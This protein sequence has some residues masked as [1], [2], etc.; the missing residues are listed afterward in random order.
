MLV[1][2]NGN[3]IGANPAEPE[4]DVPGGGGGDSI[5]VT[6][7][8]TPLSGDSPLL[9][10]FTGNAVSDQAIDESR[11]QWDF[12]SDGVID[13]YTRNTSHEYEAQPGESRLYTARLTMYGRQRQLR[14]RDRP[15]RGRGRRR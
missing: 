11:T 8:A 10:T 1:D 6:I 13:A 14:Q 5:S 7:N 3:V 4:P 12:E 2:S 15:D 9:V